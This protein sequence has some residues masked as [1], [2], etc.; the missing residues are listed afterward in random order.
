M[1]KFTDRS[2]LPLV[3]SRP[4]NVVEPRNG[5][6]PRIDTSVAVP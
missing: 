2:P 1:L 4:L 6:M 3:A 5:P